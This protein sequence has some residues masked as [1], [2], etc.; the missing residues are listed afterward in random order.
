MLS[1]GVVGTQRK[2]NEHRVPIHP[3][4]LG[5]IPQELRRHITFEHGYGEPFGLNDADFADQGHTLADR[6][7]LLQQSDIVL[8]PKPALQ[9]IKELRFNGILWGWPHCVQQTAVTQT[10]IDRKLTLI[11]F[12]EMFIWGPDG[13]RGQHTFY[14]NNELAGYCSVLHALELKGIDGHYGKQRKVVILSFGA[15]SRGAIYALKARGF[16]DITICILRPDHLVREEVLGCHY[17]RMR[18]GKEGEPRMVAVQRDGTESSLLD[19]INEADVLINGTFQNPTD[20]V[21]FVNE[22]EASYLKDRSLIIDISCDEGLGFH[23]AVPTTF[24]EPMFKVGPV[25]YYAVDHSPSYLWEAASWEISDALLRFLPVVMG[26]P[27]SWKNDE[28]IRRAIEIQE[29][30]VKNPKILSFQGRLPDYPYE[31]RA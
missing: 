16:R 31:V 10:A 27:E 13:S 11:A 20:P 29:G 8:L 28:T 5:R 21:T 19:L 3:E 9:D 18:K 14:K 7:S 26:G 24:E 12:E 25:D 23:F 30:V 17:L 1:L 2:E 6:D 4:H 15:V 22:D